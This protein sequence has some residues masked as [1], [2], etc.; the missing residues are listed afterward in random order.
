MYTRPG[1]KSG[2]AANHIRVYPANDFTSTTSLPHFSVDNILVDYVKKPTDPQWAY[3]VV[4]SKALYN[5]AKAVE[6]ELHESEEGNIVNKILEL[7]GVVINKPDL[8]NAA[9]TNQQI[10]DAKQNV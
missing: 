7:A 4:Q 5:A 3:V 1:T 9:I 6:F 10:N 8:V 2:S